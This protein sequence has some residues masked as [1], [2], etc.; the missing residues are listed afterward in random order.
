MR[1]EII[2]GAAKDHYLLRDVE[3]G[4]QAEIFTFG[5]L[6]NQ[7]SVPVGPGT[8]ERVNVIDGFADSAAARAEITD[9]FHGAKLSPYVCRLHKG[10]FDF[11]DKSYK[12]KGHYMGDSAIHGLLFDAAFAVSSTHVDEEKAILSLWYQYNTTEHGFPFPYS[13]EV[14]YKLTADRSLQVTTNVTNA[15][16]TNM[17]LNDGWHPY[18]KLGQSIDS[19]SVRFDSKELVE[20]DDALLPSGKTSIYQ[21]FHSF[22]VFGDTELDNCFTLN[23]PAY[24]ED[25]P[26]FEIKDESVGL[27]IGIYPD[28]AYPFLQIYTPPSRESIAVENLSSI[29]DSFNNKTGLITLKPGESRVFN[30]TYKL[31]LL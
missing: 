6:L 18:F 15:G 10:S 5:A 9:G 3:N 16:K 29:P 25:L 22:K 8:A 28:D 14:I 1:F 12:V 7:F 23:R 13:I 31:T 27:S 21:N 24:N 30:T 20:F 19:A 4:T 17:P 2:P 26:A 11:E